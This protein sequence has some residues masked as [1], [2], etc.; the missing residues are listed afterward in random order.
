MATFNYYKNVRENIIY[1][2]M[3]RG[4]NWVY[5]LV[6]FAKQN[7]IATDV[8][9]LFPVKNHWIIKSGY[10]RVVVAASGNITA[11]IGITAGGQEIDAAFDPVADA[12]TWGP[13]S[14]VLDN[15]PVACTVDTYVYL[16]NLD[17][18]AISG[19]S[20]FLFEIVIPPTDAD[21]L[22]MGWT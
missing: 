14:V 6:D 5:V 7:M 8:I 3:K 11:D 9:K 18:T 4:S 13:F 10:H 21:S 20:E 19:T 17:N 22:T 16:E 2:T 1:P 12:T 15:A